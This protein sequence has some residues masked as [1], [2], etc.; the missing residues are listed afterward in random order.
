MFDVHPGRILKDEL[1]ARA[2]SANA[3]A[4]ALRIPSS[5]ITDILNGR[6]G[7]SADTALRLGRFFGN[8]PQFWLNLQSS[9]ELAV[10]RRQRGEKIKDEV[11][12]AA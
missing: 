5:R 12:P 3:L 9:H 11:E 1:E 10:V 6:R 4:L 2:M 8:D 7:I